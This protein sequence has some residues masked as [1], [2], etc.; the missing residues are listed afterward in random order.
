[1]VERDVRYRVPADIVFVRTS[2]TE[3]V[4][5]F[6]R[7]DNNV[8]LE[9]EGVEFVDTTLPLLRGGASVVDL[10]ESLAISEAEITAILSKLA[11]TGA[12]RR[13]EKTSTPTV[14]GDSVQRETQGEP[15]TKVSALGT[16]RLPVDDGIS[17]EYLDSQDE[18]DDCQ[19]DVL[20]SLTTG[21]E[22][23]FHHDVL[24]RT[25][26]RDVA[27]LPGRLHEGTI[28]IGPFTV[29]GTGVCYNCYDQRRRASRD[30]ERLQYEIEMAREGVEAS[31]HPAVRS[32]AGAL[33][34]GQVL[35][36][37]DG[38]PRTLTSLLTVDP[39][40]GETSTSEIIRVPTCTIC[41]TS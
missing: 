36:L 30:D 26:Q 9:G 8:R 33:L 3:G 41:E 4:L 31:Y 5:S 32:M 13:A 10:A 14:T 23:D 11:G 28:R 38:S 22:P 24:E 1:M 29:P 37:I 15:G 25:V 7:S 27:W 40:A 18:I 39:I 19:G 20:V 17:V 16:H 34:V 35:A 12:L 2:E 6:P 21:V